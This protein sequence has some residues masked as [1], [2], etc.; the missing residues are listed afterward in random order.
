MPPFFHL[1]GRDAPSADEVIDELNSIAAEQQFPVWLAGA[2]IM[3]GYLLAAR[4]EAAM[5]LAL[6][7]KGLVKR[8]ATGSSW[9]ET[10]FRGLLA[11]I[12]QEA[13]ESAEALSLLESA[14]AMAG[15]TGERWFEAELQRLRGQCLITQGTWAAAEECFQRA[16]EAA[17]KQQ[18]RL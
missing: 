6:A 10:Y 14:L 17:Q 8:Q 1:L 4:G 13:G 2:D 15:G 12:A 16:L 18:A 5:A 7:R 3:R 11:R 9:H